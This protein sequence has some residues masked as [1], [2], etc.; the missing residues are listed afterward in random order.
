M[1]WR[2]QIIDRVKKKYHQPFQNKKWEKN[3]QVLRQGTLKPYFN[4]L[5]ENAI[6]K[7]KKSTLCRHQKFQAQPI[8]EEEFFLSRNKIVT[9]NSHIQVR[10]LQLK[11]IPTVYIPLGELE[12]SGTK[13]QWKYLSTVQLLGTQMYCIKSYLVGIPTTY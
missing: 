4:I 3:I 11:F 1:L 10:C 2:F 13:I 12:H 9:S 8:V 6:K 7:K 5:Q